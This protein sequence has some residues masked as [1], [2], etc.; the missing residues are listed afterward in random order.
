MQSWLPSTLS[1]R[2]LVLAVDVPQLQL[3][4]KSLLLARGLCGPGPGRGAALKKF[5]RLLVVLCA[6]KRQTLIEATGCWLACRPP[7][8]KRG[9]GPVH[10][11]NRPELF[12]V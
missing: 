5:S 7:T 12:V 4:A 9:K 3:Q 1:P 10:A 6:V 11:R 8:A 2:R